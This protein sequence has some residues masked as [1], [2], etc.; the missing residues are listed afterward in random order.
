MAKIVSYSE[1]ASIGMHGMVLV[2]RAGETIN[3][4]KIADITG[5]SRHHVAKV[6]QRLVKEGFLSSN[7]GPSG[8]FNL[9]LEPANIT[10]LQIYE[11]IEGQVKIISCP[12]EKQ[13]CPF[14]KCILGSVVSKM[15]QTF[16][17]HLLANTLADLM[18]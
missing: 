8:G 9:T 16:R 15:T 1:A 14:D 17:D 11:A 2:A 10:L 4:Q 18:E 13:V 5:S 7:R 6:M 12:H 3:V